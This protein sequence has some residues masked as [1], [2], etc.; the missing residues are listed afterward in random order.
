MVDIPLN[1]ETKII[2]T[3]NTQLIISTIH[4]TTGWGCFAFT[5]V[6][7]PLGIYLP[8]PPPVMELIVGQIG[9][10]NIVE[11][12]G[13]K[14]KYWIQTSFTSLGNILSEVKL[15]CMAYQPLWVI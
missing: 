4:S 9:F 3:I 15:V 14:E 8:P 11:A 10:F 6:A 5:L 2:I 7:M 13:P 12:T 1:K